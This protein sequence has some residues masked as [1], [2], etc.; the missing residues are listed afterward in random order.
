MS[1]PL[2]SDVVQL[3]WTIPLGPCKGQMASAW[4]P[5]RDS[6]VKRLKKQFGAVETDRVRLSDV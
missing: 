3:K 4:L 5:S 6:E 1:R 2:D